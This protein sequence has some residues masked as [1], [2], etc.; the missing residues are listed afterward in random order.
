MTIIYVDYANTS[1]ELLAETVLLI[2]KNF[3]D[4]LF[5]PKSFEVFQE[6]SEET[7]LEAKAMIEAALQKKQE[8]SC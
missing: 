4:G 7:L 5:L 3:P 6:C 8:E 2:S 1:T